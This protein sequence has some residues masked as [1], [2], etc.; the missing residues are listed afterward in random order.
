MKIYH[1]TH[2][3]ESQDSGFKIDLQWLDESDQVICSGSAVVSRDPEGYVPFLAADLRIRHADLFEDLT[4]DEEEM[5]H[6]V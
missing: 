5:G 4:Q 1:T 2:T 6:E 3:I